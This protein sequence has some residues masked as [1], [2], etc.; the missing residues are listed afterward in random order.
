MN[1]LTGIFF[2]SLAPLGSAWGGGTRLVH[3]DREVMMVLLA[4]RRGLG[5]VLLV[6]RRGLGMILLV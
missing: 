1:F 6:Q 3:R 4:Q 2:I 5:M